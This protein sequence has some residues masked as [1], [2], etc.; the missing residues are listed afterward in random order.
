MCVGRTDRHLW[1][2]YYPAT[3]L[4]AVKTV[5]LRS[6]STDDHT[7][8]RNILCRSELDFCWTTA[9]LLISKGLNFT[10][11]RNYVKS[12]F[13]HYKILIQS[14]RSEPCKKSFF[15]A[16]KR[17]FR[18]C[19]RCL[20][21][22]GG[23][24]IPACTLQRGVGLRV[25]AQRVCLHRRCLS[26]QGVLPRWGLSKGCGRSP[27]RILRDTINKW[28]VRFLLECILV[29]FFFI[30]R[31]RSS[32]NAYSWRSETLEHDYF[33]CNFS[34]FGHTIKWSYSPSRL[35]FSLRFAN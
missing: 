10:T 23:V 14:E 24:C 34:K 6:M 3:S 8:S 20:S 17:S 19:H 31:Y 12:V 26:A 35:F 9:E 4:Q 5:N 22:C 21:V 29:F 7:G 33:Q 27:S 25:Y 30:S 32:K 15:T 13:V 11:I 1:K 28:A 2:H 16:N 18:R